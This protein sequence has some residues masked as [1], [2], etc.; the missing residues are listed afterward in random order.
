MT[1][2]VKRQ[3]MWND[4]ARERRF[5]YSE[6]MEN[7]AP[8]HAPSQPP[9]VSLVF[10]VGA[11][12][13]GHV[14]ASMALL[15]LPAVAPVV[16][17]E[18]AIDAS[19]IGYFI[20][21]VCVGQMVTLTLFGNV[22]R[23][24]GACRINQTGHGCV[25]AGMALMMAPLPVFLAAGAVVIGF[26]YGLIGPSFSHLLMRF[27]PPERRNF[28]FSLQQTGVPIGGMAAA[29][30]APAIALAFGWRWA[31]LLSVA[32]LAGVLLMMQR[33][34]AR[35]D[36]DR[37]ATARVVAP[38]PLANVVTVWR[39]L[40]LRRVALAGGAFCWAQFCVSAYAVVVCVKVFELNL[41]AAGAMLTV[42][43]IASA[44]GRV[45]VG[46]LC[47]ALHNTALVLSWNAAILLVTCVVSLWI[48]PGWPLI[49]I[50]VL[51]AV[52]GFTTGAWA[53]TVLAEAGRLAPPGA[54]SAALS[55]MFVYLNVG[56]LI[57]PVVFAN[58]YWV[59][60]S[61]AWA[62]A[63]LGLPAAIALYCLMQNKTNK[64]I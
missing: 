40:P 21:L 15:V 55:G 59:T 27:S 9:E 18:Y 45:S 49:A 4:T 62:F 35:W 26:G 47:D 36:D 39:V 3:N 57:G 20:T 8:P 38:Q 46:W 32:L 64:T 60:Q 10:L 24:F 23:R 1:L 11:L 34:R 58:T 54:A 2:R 19:L 44:L 14:M 12:L 63:S 51:F 48:A 17:R 29:L 25:A 43:Q 5:G 52:L 42:V 6:Y 41:L 50:Y 22:T 28:I 30:I 37:D 13:T 53:G 31:M 16:A 56:K 7:A 61:Y 33:G